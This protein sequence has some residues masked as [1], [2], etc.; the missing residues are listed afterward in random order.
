MP[1]IKEPTDVPAK[2]SSAFSTSF[3]DSLSHARK[4]DFLNSLNRLDIALEEAR[5]MVDNKVFDSARGKL[6]LAS[7]LLK[8]IRKDL[9]DS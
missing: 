3:F 6:G 2:R 9:N 8:E 5:A 1:P 7:R 4:M